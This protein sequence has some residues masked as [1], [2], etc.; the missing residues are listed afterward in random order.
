MNAIFEMLV[1][2]ITRVKSSKYY[3]IAMFFMILN[4]VFVY[5]LLWALGFL[6]EDYWVL[7]MLLFMGGLAYWFW[8]A[9]GLL[10]AAGKL[11]NR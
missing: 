6:P 9:I 11:T 1:E 4:G 10:D 8:S 5:L 2:I 7:Q 3:I